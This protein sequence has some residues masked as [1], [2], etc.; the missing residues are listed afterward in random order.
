[1]KKNQGGRRLRHM[2]MQIALIMDARD[3][4]M[5]RT[6]G[7]W[8]RDSGRVARVCGLREC[9][10]MDLNNSRTILNTLTP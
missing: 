3:L 8:A 4:R 1:M 5:A 10:R 6:C 7:K 9:P 2:A